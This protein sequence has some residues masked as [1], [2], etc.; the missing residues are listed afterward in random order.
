MPIGEFSERS[1]LSAKRLRT[2]AAEGLLA[3]AAVDPGS[4]YRY[5]SLGQ[6]ADARVID[7]L[8]QA[9]VPLVEIGA[10][11]RNPSRTQLEVWAR[12]L[13]TDA[14]R[15]QDALALARRSVR[16]ERE[17]NVPDREP[18]F[19]GGDHDHISNR[20]SYRHRAA[21]REQRRCHSQD[22]SPC[23]RRRWNGRTSWWRDRSECRRR[24]GSCGL[25]RTITRRARSRCSCSELGDSGPCGRGKPD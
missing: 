9:G 19:Q 25:H 15:R 14:G 12:Q 2:Y 1:G 11:V 8:R 13:Q 21:A 7:A 23:A 3:P 16:C 5:Y 24:S 22:G 4:G 18:R 10:F 20:G 6:L 17:P